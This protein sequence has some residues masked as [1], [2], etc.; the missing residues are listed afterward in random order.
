MGLDD[1]VNK[2]LEVAAYTVVYGG[3]AVLLFGCVLS[4]LSFALWAWAGFTFDNS[5]PFGW[6]QGIGLVL[7]ILAMLTLGDLVK[8]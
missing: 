5:V 6:A 3:T 8:R 4:M 7:A 2:S 1:A